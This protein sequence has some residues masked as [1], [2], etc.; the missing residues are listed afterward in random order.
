MKRNEYSYSL[1]ECVII[2]SHKNSY[3]VISL[4][5][6]CYVFIILFHFLYKED[7]HYFGVLNLFSH[8]KL[9]RSHKYEL[10][11]AG[12][13]HFILFVF[14][15]LTLQKKACFCYHF[16]IYFNNIYVLKLPNTQI[17]KIH[18]KLNNFKIILFKK[19][20]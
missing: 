10:P 16:S 9:R 15:V 4:D 8:S 1:N 20:V 3:I 19:P 14:A 5:S 7:Y 18:E 11:K 6:F 17:S 2:C 12:K 13:S